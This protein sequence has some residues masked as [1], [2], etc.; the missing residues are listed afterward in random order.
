MVID[1]NTVLESTFK[2]VIRVFVFDKGSQEL[3]FQT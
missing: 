3:T 1:D 2:G